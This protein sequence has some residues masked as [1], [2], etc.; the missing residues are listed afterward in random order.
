MHDHDYDPTGMTD[1]KWME[2]AGKLSPVQAAQA[3]VD[4]IAAGKSTLDQEIE[5]IGYSHEKVRAQMEA[6][7]SASE[8]LGLNAPKPNRP[9]EFWWVRVDE[10]M[11]LEPACVT[12][13]GDALAKVQLIGDSSACGTPIEDFQWTHTD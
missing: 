8:Q 7:R 4:R 3:A 13:T 9:D 11:P 5:R 1:R 10:D 12:F 6:E 2:M